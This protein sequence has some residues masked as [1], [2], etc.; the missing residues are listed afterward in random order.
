MARSYVS[1]YFEYKSN[2]S[3]CASYTCELL[4]GGITSAKVDRHLL[5]QCCLDVSG[6]YFQFFHRLL[7]HPIRTSRYTPMH[8]DDFHEN[9]YTRIYEP[10]PLAEP[11]PIECHRSVSEQLS[12]FTSWL[13][14]STSL[15]ALYMA[16]A[17]GTLVDLERPQHSQDAHYYFQLGRAALSV[18]SIFEGQSVVA[19]QALVRPKLRLQI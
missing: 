17:L 2:R 11:D 13:T 5:F 10:Q 14:L 1:F 19:L 7:M 3:A 18:D 4:A 8:R 9:V 16:M 15:G 6:L 12:N